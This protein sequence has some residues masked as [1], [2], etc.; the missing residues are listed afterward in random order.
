MNT[1][2][3]IPEIQ[4]DAMR[5]QISGSLEKVQTQ[6]NTLKRNNTRYT[7]AN[8]ILAT[9]AT[10]LAGMA[11]TVGTAK[12]W[13]PVCLFAAL[14]SAGVTVTSKLQTA[15]RLTEASECVGR[16]KALRVETVIPTY[17]L[18]GVSAK[19]REIVS[20]YSTLDV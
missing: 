13:K 6:K 2:S 20:E 12:N 11:G 17:D 16:L 15:E 4:F 7:T 10:A 18:G 1:N 5:T 19:Y 9:L 3:T 8:I 14:C